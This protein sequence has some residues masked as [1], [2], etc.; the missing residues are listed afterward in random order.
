VEKEVYRYLNLMR[1][2]PPLFAKTYAKGFEGVQGYSKGYAWDERKASLIDEL[3]EMAPV[4]LFYPDKR[5]FDLA[6]CFAYEGG[7]LGI[8]GHDRSTTGCA[9]PSGTWGE[10]CQYGFNNGLHIVM[11]LLIDAGENNAALGHRRICTDGKYNRLG[12]AIQPNIKYGTN[13]VLDFGTG[14]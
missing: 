13:A 6:H 3:S 14:E 8:T 9:S 4:Q 5:L 7:K 11:A 12:V 1:I 2:D 10:C